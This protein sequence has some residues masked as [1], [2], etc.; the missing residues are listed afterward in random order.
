[1][2]PRNM[3]KRIQRRRLQLKMTQTEL[4]KKLGK[5][6]IY[7]T[8]LEAS[9]EKKHHR[10]PGLPTLEKLA[11]ALRVSVGDLLGERRRKRG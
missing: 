4:A 6:R 11:K 2:T 9:D 10:N 5:S 1:L 7:V 8:N 3:G